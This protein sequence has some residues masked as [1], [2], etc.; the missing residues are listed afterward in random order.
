MHTLDVLV[1]GKKVDAAAI[2]DV[3][4]EDVV[5]TVDEFDSREPEVLTVAKRDQP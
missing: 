5:V 3:A 4:F 2:N 1:E